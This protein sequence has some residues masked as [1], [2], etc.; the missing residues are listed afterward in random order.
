M[1]NWLAPFVI[2]I[3]VAFVVQTA[4]LIALFLQWRRTHQKFGRILSDLQARLGP[5][6]TRVQIML[7]ETQ[8]RV[9][10]MVADA[11]HVVYLARTQAQKVDRLFT[12]ATDRLR[13]QLNHVDRI[14]TGVMET[15]ED[16]GSGFRR[17]F[18]EPVQK[19]TAV[20]RGVKAGLDFFRT[21]RQHA[22]E[23]PAER[24]HEEELFI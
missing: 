6:L 1:D 4:I 10:N 21:R 7:E 19:A 17:S 9:S 13:S 14:L 12:E 22:G 23:E 3:A 20:I 2:I 16:A 5:I 8:P 18:W 24:S 15:L 11:A